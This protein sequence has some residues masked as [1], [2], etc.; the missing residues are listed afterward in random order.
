MTHGVAERFSLV[1]MSFTN[2]QSHIR[3]LHDGDAAIDS[4]GMFWLRVSF[5]AA[6]EH[7]SLIGANALVAPFVLGR[8]LVEIDVIVQDDGVYLPVVERAA[9]RSTRSN[10]GVAWS[11]RWG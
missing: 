8:V 3:M 5:K 10:R 6:T 2:L 1:V 4:H 11:S 7:G 9:S